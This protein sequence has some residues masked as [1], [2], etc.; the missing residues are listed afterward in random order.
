MK[1]GDGAGASLIL[2]ELKSGPPVDANHFALYQQVA[3]SALSHAL[4]LDGD[5][6]EKVMAAKS[7][8]SFLTKLCDA[9][10]KSADDTS[11]ALSE[12]SK[13]FEELNTCAHLVCVIATASS[14][15]HSQKQGME[16][17]VTKAFS[18]LTRFTEKIIPADAAFF[19]AGAACRKRKGTHLAFPK[20]RHCFISQRVTVCPYI[21]IYTTDTFFSHTRKENHNA[22]F[23]FLNRY[24]DI[25]DA[26]DEVLEQRGGDH[27][28]VSQKFASSLDN[29]DFETTDLPPP[30]KVRIFSYFSLISHAPRSASLIGPITTTV[31]LLLPGPCGK[32]T[33]N[34]VNLLCQFTR[35]HNTVPFP[36]PRTRGPND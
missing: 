21:A 8:K 6:L 23:V 12:T 20:S 11:A 34:C 26:I 27:G 7:A 3:Q 32:L 29:D 24:L 19:A 2:S 4:E 18:S 36:I 9:V 35:S 28:A 14:A 30:G 17:L 13:T 25:A 10:V 16:Q 1:S 33:P 22:A 5:D 31:F 15:A